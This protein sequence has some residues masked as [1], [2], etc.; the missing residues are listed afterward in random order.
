[1]IESRIRSSAPDLA[2]DPAV[3][4][5]RAVRAW[6]VALL[7]YLVPVSVATHWPRL[8]FAGAGTIDKFIHFIAFGTLA[9]IWMHAKPWGRASLGALFAAAWVYIDERTQAIEILGRTFS[10]HDMIAGWLGVA[11]AITL[12]TLRRARTPAGTDARE[13]DEL[14]Q[15]IAYSSPFAWTM[16]ALVSLAVTVLI[17]SIMVLARVFRG[18]ELYFGTFIYAVGFSGFIGVAVAA[19]G[20]ESFGVAY[21]RRAR[22]GALALIPREAQ[23][24]WRIGFTLAVLALLLVGYELLVR[25]I[26]GIQPEPE[27]A[28]DHEG[29]IVL[30][31]GFLVASIIVAF[32][33]GGT[34][35][36]RAACRANPSLASR[37]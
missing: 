23:P 2:I 19:T 6:R 13:D 18:E 25:T 10:I 22:G 28:T 34:I 32:A 14:V 16:A 31:H 8:G 3:R 15:D 1:M 20:V 33:A 37:R 5:A 7:S 12:Y 17:G 4:S 30:R 29:F 21:A 24:F 35:G 11:M 26:F 9:W 36:A 27:L